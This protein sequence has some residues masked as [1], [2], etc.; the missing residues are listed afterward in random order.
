MILVV[1]GEVKQGL[2]EAHPGSPW[3]P[4][5]VPG[6]SEGPLCP[7]SSHFTVHELG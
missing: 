1:L 2:E 4:D 3:D 5:L 7:T 6:T